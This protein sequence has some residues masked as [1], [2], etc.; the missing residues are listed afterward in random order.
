MKFFFL[1]FLLINSFTLNSYSQIVYI[2]INFILNT[3]EVGKSLNKYIK[4][5]SNEYSIDYSKIEKNLVQKE[6]E[7]IAQQNIIDK[8]EFE[9]KLSNLSK[10]INKYRSDK[11]LS[12][13]SLNK[14]KLSNTNKIL[15]ILNPIITEY[16]DS[17]SISLVIPKKNIVIGKKNL[18]ITDDVIVLLNKQLSTLNFK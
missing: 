3:S 10:E 5:L 4:E 2:D 1:I 15:K 11:K 6:K 13:E 7:L 14:I 8:S 16:V 18:D 17:N 12:Q 9:K